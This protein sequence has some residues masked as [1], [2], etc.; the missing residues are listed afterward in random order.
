[1]LFGRSQEELIALLIALIP[2]FTV[3]EFAHAWSA[4]RLGDPTA[5]NLGRLTL[6][7][8][9]H[10]DLFGMLMVLV[11]GFGWAKPVPVNV[12][13]LRNGRRD[14]ALVAAA[15]PLSNLVMAVIAG[16]IL[17]GLSKQIEIP[18][19][20]L[21]GI[22]VFVWLNVALLFFNLLPIAPL[23]GFKVV[24]GWL[25]EPI[26]ESFAKTAPWGMMIL[27][28]LILL[29]SFGSQ[30][31]LPDLDILDTLVVQPTDKLVSLLMGTP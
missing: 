1:M 16:L 17:R 14:L 3:H 4:Y 30:V 28:V 6:N 10:L 15:G 29:G 8:I 19:A 2:A 12:G 11:A 5:K 21:Y 7:P 22:V 26:A 25:P 13:N 20:V 24:L 18:W 9:R 23:D 31:G 27:L